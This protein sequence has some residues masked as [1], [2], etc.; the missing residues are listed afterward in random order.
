M[1][2]KP[3]SLKPRLRFPFSHTSSTLALVQEKRGLRAADESRCWRISPII[4]IGL[5]QT[6]KYR[7]ATYHYVSAIVDFSIFSVIAIHEK[8]NHVCLVLSPPNSSEDGTYNIF[9]IYLET[10]GTRIKQLQAQI[11]CNDRTL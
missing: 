5:Q 8:I 2:R 11:A 4:S 3:C 6:Q 1:K 10:D 9:Q 7:N